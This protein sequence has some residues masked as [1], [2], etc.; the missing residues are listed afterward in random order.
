MIIMVELTFY[1]GVGEI[2]GNKILLE[3]LD[4]RVLLDF[5][6]SFKQSGKYFSEFL[7]P[8]KCNGLG[9]YFA[10]DL[11]PDVPGIYR[12]DYLRH[13][14]RGEEEQLVDA[15]L[16]SHAHVDHMAYLHHLRREIELVMSRGTQAVIRTLQDTTSSGENDYLEYVP[17]FEMRPYARGEGFTRKTKKDECLNRPCDVFDYGK[18]IK[19]GDLEVVPYEVDHSLPGA[20]AY[21]IH[22]SEGTL[23]YT[24]DYRFHGYMGNKTRMMISEASEEDI[25]AVITEGTRI[26]QTE[27]TSEEEVY[28]NAKRLVENTKGLVVIT[29][30]VRDLTR[31]RTFHRIAGETGRKLVISFKQAYLLERFN[32]FTDLYPEPGDTDLCLFAERKSWGIAGRDD[33]FS[34]IEGLCYPSNICEQDYSTWEREYLHRENTVNHWDIEDQSKYILI[35]GYFQLNS[36]V[37]INPVPGSLYIRSITE[38]FDDEMELDA[39]RVRNW[40]D[41]FGLELHGMSNEDRLHASGHANGKQIVDALKTINPDKIIPIHTENPEHL[42]KYFENVANPKYGIKITL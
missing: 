15:V 26:K 30:P 17:N 38:P 34:N 31:F 11:L 2:G 27:S 9:D 40:L 23:L 18:K 42:K 36:L 13:M 8:R 24:G 25:I 21:M 4:T 10:T 12:E 39:E 7:Q 3:D 20:T 19:I 22:T 5:G 32:E 41:L 16:I 35:C 37:D 1:G 29:F 28:H 14:G 33:Y 6:M